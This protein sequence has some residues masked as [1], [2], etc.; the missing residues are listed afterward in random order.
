MAILGLMWLAPAATTRPL[1]DTPPSVGYTIDGINGTNSWYRGSTGGNYVV[2]H[3]TVSDPDSAI[4]STSGCEPAIRID[5]PNTGTTRT[6]TATSGGGTTAV[7]TKTLKV[8]ADPPTGVSAAAARAPDQN[9]WY[10]HPVGITWSGNDVTSGIASCASITYSGPDSGSAAPGGTCTDQAG[11]S[12]GTVTYPLKFDDTGPSVTASASRGSDTNGW[13]NHAVTVAWAAT[14]PASGVASCTSPV[15]YNGP[16]SASAAPSGTCTDQAG[17]TSGSVSFPLKFDSTAPSGVSAAAARGPDQNGWY[18]HA[19]AIS[20]SGSDGT[21]GIASCSSI[22]YSGPDSANA[23]PSGNC[24]DKAGNT[25]SSVS[26]PL[27]FDDTAPSVTPSAARGPDTNGWYNHAVTISWAGSDSL[28]GLAS[29]TSPLNYNGPDSGSAAPSGTCTDNAGNI[30]ASAPFPLKFDGTAPTSISAA[31][32]RAADQDG[33]YNH[34]VGV[35][36]SGSDATSGIGSCTSITYGGPDSGSAAPSGACTDKAGNTSSAVSFPLKFDGTAPTGVSVAAARSPDNNGWFNHAIGINWTGNDATSGIGTCTAITY[37]G[38]DSG[39][40]SQPGSCTDKAGNISGV[41]SFP[42]KYDATG[43][44]V[45]PTAGRA[46]D[47]N[48][49]YNHPV[50]IAWSGSDAVSGLDACSSQ[51]TYSGPDST[52][53]SVSGSCTD[54]AG[55]TTSTAFPLKFDATAPAVTATP[56]RSADANGWYNHPVTITWSATDAISGVDSCS[57]SKSYAGPDGP[58]AASAGTCVDK[59]GNIGSATSQIKY[60]A[61]PPVVS[62]APSRAPDATGWYNHALTIGWVGADSAS[63]VDSCSSSITYN[64]PDDATASTSGT[65]TDVA[66]NSAPA[67]TFPF[68]FDATAPVATL[69]SAARPPDQSGWYNHPVLITWAGTDNLSGIAACTASPYNGPD[70]ETAVATGTCVDTAGNRSAALTFPLKFDATAPVVS[71]SPGRAADANGWYNHAVTI[72]WS[73]DDA[74]SGLAGCTPPLTYAGPDAASAAPSGIC[75]DK[76]GNVAALAFPLRYDSTAPAVSARADRAPDHNGWY[77]HPLSV[78]FVGED[79]V[80]GV[81]SCTSTKYGGPA[82]KG[83][84]ANGSCSDRA[85]NSGSGTLS[86]DYDAEPP[87]LSRLAVESQSDADVVRWKPSSSDDV[88]TITRTARG[89]RPLTVYRG[90]GDSFVDKKIRAGTEYRYSV[91]TQDQAGNESRRL[92]RL[93]LPKAVSLRKRSYTPRTAGPPVLRLPSVAGAS[94]YHVQLFRHGKRI[95]AAWPLRPQLSLRASWKWAGHSY[96][97]TQGR[98]RWFAWAGFGRRSAARYKLLGSAYF[99]VGR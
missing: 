22:N 38:P 97:L 59:A 70:S 31:A 52:N 48:G 64:G 85:G 90:G 15:N 11:N 29:C 30:S 99:V 44:A 87:I 25:S 8:D 74:T 73:G 5:G 23:A 71:A 89:G 36:W 27:K 76:A 54:T 66:G 33:W 3:W 34:A 77:N 72:G 49:W 91:R 45:T 50:T 18:N 19:V 86:I 1:D 55:N 51:A 2:V 84:A 21:A 7:T 92:S 75:T 57:A 17:N 65:C 62:P 60:D 46:A 12:S 10:N 68:K 39:S 6:C 98:Y 80:S 32:A 26:F 4:T 61:T 47:S 78:Q 94:Y 42:F 35:T 24:S 9:G 79:G 41:V 43:P 88:A 28:S 14:D 40:A 69:A 95:L 16:D 93:A 37:S 96:R 56:G 20:W 13:Y 81:D 53:A 58:N 67:V 83:I 63:G 82:G